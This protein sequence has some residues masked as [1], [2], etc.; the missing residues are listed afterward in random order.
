MYNTQLCTYFSDL[1]IIILAVLVVILSVS[2][3]VLSVI[4]QKAGVCPSYCQQHHLPSESCGTTK[5][6]E[7][8]TLPHH[9]ESNFKGKCNTGQCV[10]QTIASQRASPQNKGGSTLPPLPYEPTVVHGAVTEQ[11]YLCLEAVSSPTCLPQ[12]ALPQLPLNARELLKSGNFCHNTVTE[13][14]DG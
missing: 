5:F 12:T 11:S 8:S 7:V 14:D 1:T 13:D 10:H 4:L 9:S 3:I 2:V 6:Q